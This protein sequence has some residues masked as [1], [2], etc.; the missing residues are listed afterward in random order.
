[1]MK[2]SGES[3]WTAGVCAGKFSPR[4]YLVE[5]GR[6][7]YR[8]NRK[9]VRA[10]QVRTSFAGE[11]DEETSSERAEEK[12]EEQEIDTAGNPKVLRRSTRT[13]KQP[14]WLQDYDTST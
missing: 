1:M 13:R 11:E 9:Q 6:S 7:T 12:V 2:L 8:R 14:V 4:S 3:T 10:K 5:V